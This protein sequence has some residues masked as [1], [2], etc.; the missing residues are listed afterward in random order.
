[1]ADSTEC[2]KSL[3]NHEVIE[4]LDSL[5]LWFDGMSKFISM[6]KSGWENAPAGYHLLAQ[7]LSKHTLDL[8]RDAKGLS[9]RIAAASAEQELDP[10]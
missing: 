7:K 1:M 6:T 3:S 2:Q 5:S 9:A 8:K 4:F 10:S